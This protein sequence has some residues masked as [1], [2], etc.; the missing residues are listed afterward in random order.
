MSETDT[1]EAL[2]ETAS[3]LSS[4]NRRLYLD[5][6]AFQKKLLEEL[7]SLR[8]LCLLHQVQ[9][10]PM[11]QLNRIIDIVTKEGIT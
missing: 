10:C 6:L 1:I 9:Q 7:G 5:Q 4:A 3:R 11:R 2:Q 8:E